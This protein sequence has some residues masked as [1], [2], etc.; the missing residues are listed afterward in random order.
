MDDSD[1]KKDSVK[2][3]NDALWEEFTREFCDVAP[4][5]EN[6]EALLEQIDPSSPQK[7]EDK[8]QI[9]ETSQSTKKELPLVSKKQTPQLDRRTEERLRKGKIPIEARIDLHGMTRDVA[10]EALERFI[11]QSYHRGLRHVLVIT[12]KGKSKSTT[13]DWL[14]VGQGVLKTNVPFW[15]DGMALKPYIL[16]YMSAQP[17]DGGTGALYVYLKRQR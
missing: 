14:T 11:V 5:E 7:P 2:E 9:V 12:G 4:E 13:D 10:H 8:S 6:F 16:K 15:L 1:N 3:E 17:K